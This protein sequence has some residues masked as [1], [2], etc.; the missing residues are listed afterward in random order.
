MENYYNGTRT[1]DEIKK[2]QKFYGVE[3]DGKWGPV[4]TDAA[5]GMSADEAWEIYEMETEPEPEI[6][7]MPEPVEE[8]KP[9][10]EREF[11][12]SMIDPEP[13]WEMEED[14][15]DGWEDEETTI[16][17]KVRLGEVE[18]EIK[19]LSAQR[20]YFDVSPYSEEEQQEQ[21]RRLDSLERERLDLEK[22]V[23]AEKKNKI[24]AIDE[25]I[26]KTDAASA[27]LARRTDLDEFTKRLEGAKLGAQRNKLQQEKTDIDPNLIDK[28]WAG[29][30]SIVANT[31]G[32]VSAF[33][34][35]VKDVLT[36]KGKDANYDENSKSAQLLQFAE[37]QTE[38]ATAESSGIG[39]VLG[40]SLIDAGQSA[41]YAPLAVVNPALPLI[42]GGVVAAGK[43]A[44]E[45]KR[46][47]ATSEEA[48]GNAVLIGG[49]EVLS[50]KIPVTDVFKF[51]KTEAGEHLLATAAKQGGEEGVRNALNYLPQYL[52]NVGSK[53]TDA[54][55]SMEDFLKE[56]VS[57]VPSSAMGDDG[58]LARAIKDW[59]SDD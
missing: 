30:S 16:S 44:N 56:I 36:G 45:N 21:Q 18:R 25:E 35:T 42:L 39:K 46:D 12:G 13:V 2:L 24:A 31:A 51:L 10:K 49:A 38:R 5:F 7:P 27:A 15:D 28:A 53:G 40:E 32:G 6:V 20:S 3:E 11:L 8:K 26:R 4:S 14:W 19:S 47:G 41:A 29:F 54:R 17:P 33:G 52:I 23:K 50:E 55:F 1:E 48:L 58:W 57:G 22:Q 59:D 37:D 9:E 34:E 43:K